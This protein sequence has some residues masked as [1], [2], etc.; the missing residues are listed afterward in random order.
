MKAL[1][2]WNSYVETFRLSNHECSYSEYDCHDQF[3]NIHVNI[4]GHVTHP[5]TLSNPQ[6]LVLSPH[7][8]GHGSHSYFSASNFPSNMPQ[9]WWQHWARIPNETGH[10][11]LVGEW[12]PLCVGAWNTLRGTA[13]DAALIA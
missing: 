6:K 7:I 5:I 2:V 12:G 13:C 11:V 3:G 1:S 4:Q 8:Y 10:A 9:I